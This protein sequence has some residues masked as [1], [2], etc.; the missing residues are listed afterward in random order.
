MPH[1]KRDRER[2]QRQKEVEGTRMHQLLLVK[3]YLEERSKPESLQPTGL[4]FITISR[5]AASGGHLLAHVLTTDFLKCEGDLFKGWHVFDKELCELVALD[6]TL[7][8][9]MEQLLKE[10]YRSEMTE[11][12]DS[13][14]LGRSEQ[15]MTLKKTFQIVRILALV[16]KVII[17]GRAGAFV[18]RGMETGVHLRL[19]A[20]ERNRV[21]WMMRKLKLSHD[22]SA[23]LIA[24]QDRERRKMVGA[25]FDADI[26]DPLRY[27]L[28]VNAA[29]MSPHE[30]SHALIEILRARFHSDGT[31]KSKE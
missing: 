10:R 24:K 28:T 22:E 31:L 14:F 4:P 3:Q 23:T 17:V 18:T 1:A 29:T 5:Q 13:I 26:E 27:D 21:R 25:F 20:P 19:V 7:H 30:I 8:T 2:G 11:L 16:G 6:P 15:Y 9:S 12:F